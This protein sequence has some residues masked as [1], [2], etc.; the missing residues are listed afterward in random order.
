MRPTSLKPGSRVICNG[1]EYEFIRRDRAQGGQPAVNVLRG[2]HLR[3]LY[4]PTDDGK[5][6][7]TDFYL[8]RNC[9]RA[10]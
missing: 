2:D 4:G 9:R 10:A 6:T 1:R 8:S 3:G 5:C 7:M